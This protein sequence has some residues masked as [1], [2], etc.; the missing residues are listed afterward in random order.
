MI[1]SAGDFE[2]LFSF[3]DYRNIV[4]EMGR[5]LEAISDLYRVRD[6]QL[7]IDCMISE[8]NSKIVN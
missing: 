2:L 4:I 7:I 3:P 5:H 6:A 8:S 1:Q